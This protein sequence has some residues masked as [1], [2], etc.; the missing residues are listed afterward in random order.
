MPT[1]SSTSV[2]LTISKPPLTTGLLV[3]LPLPAPF[4][5]TVSLLLETTPLWVCTDTT[6]VPVLRAVISPV[7]LSSRMT[8]E[9]LT[10]LNVRSAMAAAP[11]LSVTDTCGTTLCAGARVT[12]ALAKEA[13]A[14][15]PVTVRAQA[16]VLL[17]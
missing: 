7:A 14:G 15:I 11:L 4:T 6:E 16:A 5:T 8:S 12:E 10:M 9:P 1:P 13:F 17:L 3:W 2:S